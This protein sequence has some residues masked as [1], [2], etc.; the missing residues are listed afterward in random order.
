MLID[1]EKMFVDLINPATSLSFVRSFQ[2]S[3]YREMFALTFIY[4]AIIQ[5]ELLGTAQTRAKLADI[6]NKVENLTRL[7][8]PCN[9]AVIFDKLIYGKTK[10][11]I[12]RRSLFE[13]VEGY[14]MALF[15]M[16]ESSGHTLLST[17]QLQTTLPVSRDA[18]NK[19]AGHVASTKLM[20]TNFYDAV[21]S[22]ELV[23]L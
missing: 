2:A 3:L 21:G 19:F 12:G 7:V 16:I 18:R 5:K 6:P 1:I 22:V 15:W 4:D 20:Y 9:L 17:N 14:A 10:Q 11:F 8:G 13:C 23:T